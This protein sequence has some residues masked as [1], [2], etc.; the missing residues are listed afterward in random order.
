MATATITSFHQG[1]MS[2]NTEISGHNVII[3][4]DKNGGGQNLG[5]RPKVLMLVSLAGCTGLD[6][7]S[8]LNKQRVSFSQLS[9]EVN[10][11]LT[12]EDPKIYDEV[13][14][15]YKIKVDKKDEPKVARAVQLSQDKYCGV[16]AM[17][18]A[19]AKLSHR[20]EFIS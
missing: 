10:A 9:I 15:I 16:S 5:T 13:S 18:R 8:I 6:V 4:T 12:E 20:I 11:H 3:D 1:G 19:F 7:V 2:F 14:V 17:F